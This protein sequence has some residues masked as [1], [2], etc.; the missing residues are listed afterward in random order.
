MIITEKVKINVNCGNIKYI[1]NAGYSVK[2]NDEIDF[3]VD[4]LPKGSH[5][6][7]E[8]KCEECETLK[9][10]WYKK[11]N[12]CTSNGTEIYVCLK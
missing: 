10:M 4:K 8:C 3:F 5:I 1:K 11:Y 7:I 2:I 12:Q 6:I 9:N